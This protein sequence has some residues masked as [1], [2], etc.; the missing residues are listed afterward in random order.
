M[1]NRKVTVEVTHHCG[2]YVTIVVRVKNCTADEKQ[3]ILKDAEKYYEKAKEYGGETYDLPVHTP[4][5]L[6]EVI[7]NTTYVFWDTKSAE[8]YADDIENI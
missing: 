5:D 3:Q 2:V 1:S 6:G 7:F 4:I 8:K